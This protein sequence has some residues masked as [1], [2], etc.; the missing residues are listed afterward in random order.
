MVSRRPLLFVPLLAVAA[1]LLA[2]EL[3]VTALPDLDF[4]PLSSRFAH[5]V[6]L[7]LTAFICLAR[8]IAVRRERLAWLLIGSGVLAWTAGELRR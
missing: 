8:A 3:R 7:A 1:W 2:Y 6:V 4:S 5:D